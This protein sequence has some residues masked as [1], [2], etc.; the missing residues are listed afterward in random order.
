MAANETSSETSAD[1]SDPWAAVDHSGVANR[2]VQA[3]NVRTET[4]GVAGVDRAI[5]LLAAQPGQSLLD[6][7]CG[8]GEAVRG[9][10]HQVGPAGR[11]VGLDPSDTLLAE[12][13]RRSESFGATVDFRL[14]DAHALPFPDAS[15]D[16]SLATLVFVH[17]A[18]PSRA[19]AEMA[20]VTRSGA[21]V[22]LRE[23]DYG[24]MAV[25]S[26]HPELTRTILQAR[27]DA[28]VNGWIGRQLPGL[29]AAVGLIDIVVEPAVIIQRDFIATEARLGMNFAMAAERAQEAGRIS[30]EEATR[31][32]DEMRAT[33]EAGTYFQ[34]TTGFIVCGRKP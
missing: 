15:F 18:D 32:L 30:A 28:Y 33:S 22:V 6:V 23:N 12:A 17:L 21:T 8:I 20:R 3:L 34:S 25:D 2:F 19:L 24:T 7:G 1:M 4:G 5:E 9:L 26:I 31:W 14:G 11:V 29:F 10:A 27:C 13:W 16:G